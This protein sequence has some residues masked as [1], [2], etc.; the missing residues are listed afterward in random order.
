M[1]KLT[2]IFD[3]DAEREDFIGWYL[4]GGGEQQFDYT[5][6]ETDYRS[7]DLNYTTRD[8]IRITRKKHDPEEQA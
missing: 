5:L 8:E 6:P 7:N 1:S 2:L 3:N 4:D